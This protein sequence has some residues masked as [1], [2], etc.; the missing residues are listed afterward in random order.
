MDQLYAKWVRQAEI[1]A[2]G[3]EHMLAA[4]PNNPDIDAVAAQVVHARNQIRIIEARIVCLKARTE[5]CERAL[6]ATQLRPPDAY[7]IKSLE[8]RLEGLKADKKRLESGRDEWQ[9]THDTALSRSAELRERNIS[10]LL[11]DGETPVVDNALPQEETY[12]G[13]PIPT[14]ENNSGAAMG[15]QRE[16]TQARE[17]IRHFEAEIAAVETR[18]IAFQ[19]S[20]TEAIV[21]GTSVI[22]LR[23][24][25]KIIRQLHVRKG[26]LEFRRDDWKLNLNTAPQPFSSKL[27]AEHSKRNGFAER[28]GN[29]DGGRYRT[30]QCSG[31]AR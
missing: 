22:K 20:L 1:D 19:Q 21:H 5:A 26:E 31:L 23:D 6:N 15:V 30:Q 8:Q 7:R 25:D 28:P 4:A 16:I 2:K 17:R 24:I 13:Q 10:D 18:I 11:S 29:R 9:R 14:P 3:L 12:R 27:P